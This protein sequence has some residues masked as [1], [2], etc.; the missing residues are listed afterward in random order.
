MICLFLCIIPKFPFCQDKLT[1]LK[2][3]TPS[4]PVDNSFTQTKK[5]WKVIH[6]P[7]RTVDK[8]REF[9]TEIRHKSF[10]NDR[11]DVENSVF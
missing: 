1:D 6:N 4:K 7:Q 3:K 11:F 2:R 5:Q 10:H 9:S 8:H